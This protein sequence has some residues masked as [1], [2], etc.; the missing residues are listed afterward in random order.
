MSA[1]K[2]DRLRGAGEPIWPERRPAELVECQRHESLLNVAFA[3]GPS[4]ADPRRAMA[5]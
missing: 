3:D 4:V 5:T 2:L 1:A